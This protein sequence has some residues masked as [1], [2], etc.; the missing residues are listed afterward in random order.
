[1]LGAILTDS[2]DTTF[3]PFNFEVKTSP[4]LVCVFSYVAVP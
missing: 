4:K 2:V 3:T 1:M